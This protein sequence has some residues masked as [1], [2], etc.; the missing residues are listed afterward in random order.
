MELTAREASMVR[1]ALRE[2]AAAYRRLAKSRKYT[3]PAFA[4]IRASA[5]DE[6][7]AYDALAEKAKSS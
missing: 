2:Q 1:H 4:H 3:G 6:A 7:K 5:R